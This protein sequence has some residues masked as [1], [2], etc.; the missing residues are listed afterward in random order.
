MRH[1]YC[2]CIE[3]GFC[4][5]YL[6]LRAVSHSAGSARAR[7]DRCRNGLHTS[8][9]AALPSAEVMPGRDEGQ[10]VREIAQGRPGKAFN[11]GLTSWRSGENR[12]QRRHRAI[13][14]SEQARLN[15]LQYKDLRR[16]SANDVL[17][18]VIARLP[19]WLA[20]SPERQAPRRRTPFHRADATKS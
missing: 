11:N 14:Q 18:T 3:P 8:A 10:L 15:L 13:H 4:T 17:S 7:A 19:S 6:S 5:S 9:H 12:C 2:R 16:S 20:A 1:G